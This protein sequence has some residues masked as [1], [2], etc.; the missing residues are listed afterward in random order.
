MEPELLKDQPMKAT[1]Q[2]PGRQRGFTLVELLV[3]IGIIAVMSAVS[4]PNILGYVRAARIRN[5]QDQVAGAL[6]RARNLAIMK[7]TQKGILFLTQNNTT[8][9]VHVEDTVSGLEGAGETVGFTR[10]GV[11]F[12]APNLSLSTG[13]TL[14]VNVRFAAV[15][16]DC[17]GVA[18]FASNQAALRFDRFGA[19]SVTPAPAAGPAPANRLAPVLNG[20]STATDRI[21]VPATGDFSVCL[22]DT[23]T[24]LRRVVEISAAG[25]VVRR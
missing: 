4:L 21:Y 23:L 15:A 25:R 24:N 22:W 5:A 1:A 7:N 6:Q 16:A 12:A 17:P 20:G 2:T 18:G 11:D 14:P 3:V 19:V 9:W 13:Y 8:F 10:Q